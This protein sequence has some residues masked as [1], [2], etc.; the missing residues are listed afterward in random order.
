MTRFGSGSVALAGGLLALIAGDLGCASTR[1]AADELPLQPIAVLYWEPED[2]RRRAEIEEKAKEA[3]PSDRRGGRSGR[4]GVA[5]LEDLGSLIGLGDKA[6]RRDLDRFPGNLSLVDPR[7]GAIERVEAAPRGARPMA[8]SKDGRR[9]MFTAEAGT[10]RWQLFEYDRVSREVRRLTSGARIHPVGTYGPDGRLAYLSVA[11]DG[12]TADLELRIT[13]RHGANPRPL[14]RG[15]GTDAIA[16]SSA[17]G[18][19]VY[20]QY[21]RRPGKRDPVAFLEALDPKGGGVGRTLGP[22]KAPSFSPDG[23]WLVYAV[24]DGDSSRL[25]RVRPN[26]AGRSYL[27]KKRREEADPDVS[28]DGLFVVYV[29]SEPGRHDRLFVRRFDGTGDRVLIADGGVAHPTW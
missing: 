1:I 6:T 11:V 18:P 26:G 4:M 3:G 8:W 21:R 12:Q 25:R 5:R 27:G 22:G 13:G 28:P 9:L 7:T 24:E 14:I 20:V 2:A 15:Q 17:E 29:G 10:G 19:V 23:S 16:W